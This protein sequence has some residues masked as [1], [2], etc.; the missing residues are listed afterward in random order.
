MSYGNEPAARSQTFSS[1]VVSSNRPSWPDP[2]NEIQSPPS[3]I[4]TIFDG[5]VGAMVSA[6][7]GVVGMF[8]RV[9][10][11]PSGVYRTIAG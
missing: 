2:Q 6:V 4:R 1:P 7:A 11:T 5:A 9:A 3:G 10:V 8:Q